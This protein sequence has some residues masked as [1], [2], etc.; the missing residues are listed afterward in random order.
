[1]HRLIADDLFQ[2]VRWCRPVNPAQ[3][4]KSPVEPR[5]QQ[6]HHVA[7]ECCQILV[8]LDQGEQI[9]AH[10]HQFAGAARCA[11]EPADQ[12]LAPRLGCKMQIAGIGVARLRAPALDR[13]ATAVRGR[14]RS[15]GRA[16]A[17]KEAAAGRVEIVVAVEHFA[18]HRG[19]G[20][21]AAARQQRLAQFEQF[22]GV[23]FPIRGRAAPQQRAAA[24]GNRRKQ[25]G[26][27]SGGHRWVESRLVLKPT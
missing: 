20:S 25:V 17:K 27:K 10:R 22:G 23:F 16:S 2:N 26:E 15:R 6:M 5:R 14:A 13:A 18:R 11:V 1:M 24:F 19:A 7:V 12:F 8:A 4:E 3:H 21:L 9:G